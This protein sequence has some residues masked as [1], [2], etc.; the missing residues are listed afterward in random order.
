[1]PSRSAWVA[2]ACAALVAVWVRVHNAF[3]YPAD[4]G[5]DAAANWQYIHALTRSWMLPPPDAGWSTGDPPLYFYVSAA[6]LR[7]IAFRPVLIPL[8]NVLLGLVLAGL[9]GWFVRRRAPDDGTRALLAGLLVLYLPAHVQ[10]SAMVNEELLAAVLTSLVL[11][12]LA[13]PALA[14]VA[15]GLATL[16]KLSGAL[17]VGAAALAYAYDGWCRRRPGPAATRIALLSA[18][19][20]LCGG[21]FYLRNRWLYGFFVPFGLPAH[22]LMFG[23]P[24]GERALLDY[25]YVPLATFTDPQ[26]LNPDLL[27][28]VWGSTYAS[29]WFDAH[30]FFLPTDSAAVR[31]LGT[32]TLLLALLPSAAFAVG[33]VR[34][35]RRCLRGD[36]SADAPLVALVVLTLAGYALY[37]WQNP[38]FAVLKGTSLLGLAL[39]YAC[40]AS[41]VLAGWARRGRVHALAIGAGLVALAVCV[42]I[43]GTFNGLFERTEVS[44]IRWET[45]NGR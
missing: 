36:G 1:V 21:W 38:W 28:S 41:E 5:F 12:T 31:Q 10:M 25:L 14:G 19:A 30:R 42:T 43:S 24:P 45:T 22:E 40:Y 4:W 32:A 34:G 35:A 15:G 6:V 3:A 33:L 20:L 39:P 17:S 29:V 13:R 7:A 37:A 23:M 18:A 8:L 16:T 9:A 2:A 27:R 44:G 26:L 11:L